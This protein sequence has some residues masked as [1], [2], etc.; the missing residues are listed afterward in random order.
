MRS[1]VRTSSRFQAACCDNLRKITMTFLGRDCKSNRPNGVM[2]VSVW[3]TPPSH[4]W[5][6]DPPPCLAWERDGWLGRSATLTKRTFL[7]WRFW[8]ISFETRL[9]AFASCQCVQSSRIASEKRDSQHEPTNFC[10][11]LWSHLTC[12]LSSPALC[13][14]LKEHF[15]AECLT[16][17]KPTKLKLCDVEEISCG[18]FNLSPYLPQAQR[19]NPS[20]SKSCCEVCSDE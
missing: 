20:T 14:Q 15:I 18:E 5:L 4:P 12:G 2:Y 13:K 3:R 6:A 9:F 7:F 16:K 11:S 8:I 17:W 19:R 1:S 10:A